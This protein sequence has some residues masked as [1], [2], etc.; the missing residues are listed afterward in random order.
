MKS[1]DSHSP[2]TRFFLLVILLAL[3]IFGLYQL[4]DFDLFFESGADSQGSS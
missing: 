2:G 4:A 3:G 1:R